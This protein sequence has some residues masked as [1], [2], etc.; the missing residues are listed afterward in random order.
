MQNKN[1][2]ENYFKNNIVDKKINKNKKIKNILKYFAFF[3]FIFSIIFYFFSRSPNTRNEVVKIKIEKGDSLYDLSKKL[4]KEKLIKSEIVFKVISKLRN[5]E[6]KIHIG[7]YKIDKKDSAF[8]I[9]SKIKKGEVVDESVKII[10][11]EGWPNYKIA[12]SLEKKLSKN[13]ESNFS[14]NIFLEIAKNKEGYLYPDT[15]KIDPT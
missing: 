11:F 4:K 12:D 3:V 7:K 1:I 14:K 10:I 6:K 15:Y 5:I 13:K 9:V 8:D 2:R